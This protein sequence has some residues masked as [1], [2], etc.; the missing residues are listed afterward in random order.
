MK[1]PN[2]DDAY[3]DSIGYGDEQ[4]P[5]CGYTLYSESSEDFEERIFKKD[6]N[7]EPQSIIIF[8]KEA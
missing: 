8:K 6:E 1:C 5:E 4:C 2:C 7:T 3:M